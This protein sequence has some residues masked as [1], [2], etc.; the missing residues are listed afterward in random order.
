MILKVDGSHICKKRS[1]Q[2]VRQSKENGVGCI[3]TLIH[4]P[5]AN[6]SDLTHIEAA[7]SDGERWRRDADKKGTIMRV[8]DPS[9]HIMAQHFNYRRQMIVCLPASDFLISDARW[10]RVMDNGRQAGEAVRAARPDQT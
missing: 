9:T 10:V 7:I 1:R 4:S 3:L 8:S 5:G 6:D 2:T